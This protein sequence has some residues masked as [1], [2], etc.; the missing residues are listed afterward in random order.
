MIDTACYNFIQDESK[1]DFDILKKWTN[2]ALEK[3]DAFYEEIKN[4][5]T[6]KIRHYILNNQEGLM[7]L[8]YKADVSEQK[9]KKALIEHEDQ[10]AAS[11]IAELY[12]Q[13]LIE[14]YKTKQAY[15]SGEK[16]DWIFDI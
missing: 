16:T 4:L 7:Q 10:D 15:S 8:L 6:Q 13:R 5:L 1:K 2:H 14:K 12:L 11:M 9:I 3:N